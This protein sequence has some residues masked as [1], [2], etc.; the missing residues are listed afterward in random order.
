MENLHN[1]SKEIKTFLLDNDLQKIW[2]KLSPL[3]RNEWIC[4]LVSAKKLETRLKRL[5]RLKSDLISGKKRPCCWAGCPHR[6][7]L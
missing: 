5:D 7:V 3:S 6:K 4:F 1:L 2:E